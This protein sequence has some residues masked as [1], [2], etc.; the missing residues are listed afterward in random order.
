[1]PGYMN[2]NSIFF[3]KYHRKV[4]LTHSQLMND[5]FQHTSSLLLIPKL[6]NTLK[7]I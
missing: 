7:N 4:Q 1:M 2:I 3:Y 6:F 5:V